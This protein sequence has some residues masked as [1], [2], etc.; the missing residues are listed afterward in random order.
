MS[1]DRTIDGVRDD[2]AQLRERIG[3]SFATSPHRGELEALGTPRVL[4]LLQLTATHDEAVSRLVEVDFI[5]VAWLV[6]KACASAKAAG[7]LAALEFA[8][9]PILIDDAIAKPELTARLRALDLGRLLSFFHAALRSEQFARNLQLLSFTL[10]VGAFD[11]AFRSDAATDQLPQIDYFRI[12]R[13]VRATLG[14]ERLVANAESFDQ[15]RVLPHTRQPSA[16]TTILDRLG[17][18]GAFGIDYFWCLRVVQ[19]AQ[20]SQKKIGASVKLAED[21]IRLRQE[22]DFGFASSTLRSFTPAV[23]T[24]PAQMSVNFLGLLGPNGALPIHITDYILA[25]DREQDVEGGNAKKSFSPG[26]EATADPAKKSGVKNSGVALSRFLDLFHHRCLSLFFRAWAVHQKTVDLDRA[27]RP[28]DPRRFA[29]YFASF[30]G[31]GM[32]ALRDRDAVPDMAKLYF[33]GRLAGPTRN[34]EGLAAILAEYFGV[35]AEIEDFAGHWVT[36]PETEALRLGASPATGTLGST[37]IVGSRIYQYQTKFRIRL[38]P[39]RLADLRRLLPC[40]RA[41]PQLK[42]WVWNYIGKELLW[43]AQYILLA[44]EVPQTQLGAG[45]LLGWTTWITTRTPD[46]DAEDVVIDSDLN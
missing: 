2:Y 18:T 8:R 27:D 20:A 23:G 22:A 29:N 35:R 10:L 36:I 11:D 9:I 6:E 38:G 40:E 43:D 14:A 33:S 34:A 15:R 37:A 4:A 12:M 26:A 39:M 17:K 25:R 44:R 16:P 31:L 30:I 42:A 21:Y 24:A 19:A 45:S 32:P 41:W 7:Q 13:L 46:R 5:R 28:G 1:S 3:Q